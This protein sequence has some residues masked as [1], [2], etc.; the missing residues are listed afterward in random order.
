MK[1]L[2][3]GLGLL[4]LPLVEIALL[5]RAGQKL[6]LWP[7]MAIIVGTGIL[8]IAVLV[9]QRFA[10]VSGVMNAVNEGKPPL[11]PVLNGAF[12]VLAGGLLFSPGL[13]CDA[14]GLLLL[15]PPIR[16]LV[17]GWTVARLLQ[18]AEIHVATHADPR[19]DPRA[20]THGAGRL[21]PGEREGGPIIEGEFERLGERGTDPNRDGSR[22]R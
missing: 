21:T 10:V 11:E 18:D 8:G 9:R 20:D 5:I 4:A 1:R 2:G 22:K 17:A 15:V 3:I 13:L 6:G 7:V 16:R 14:A 12:L 19:G